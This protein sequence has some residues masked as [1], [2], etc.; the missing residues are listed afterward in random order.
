MYIKHYR[1]YLERKSITVDAFTVEDLK[2][3]KLVLLDGGHETK[4]SWSIFRSL[5]FQVQT[6]D[7]YSY[8]FSDGAWF[9]VG[10]LNKFE[11]WSDAG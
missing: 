9:Q 6:D 11:I 8:H 10:Q 3:D 2:H 4:D 1:Q 7:N 5:V